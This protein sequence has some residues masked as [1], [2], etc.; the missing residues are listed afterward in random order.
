MLLSY[1]QHATLLLSHVKKDKIWTND[2]KARLFS[3]IQCSPWHKMMACRHC[4]PTLQTLYGSA[5]HCKRH[6]LS[7]HFRWTPTAQLCPREAFSFPVELLLIH[8]H[9]QM[10]LV[11]N[12]RQGPLCHQCKNM[13]K[14]IS[15]AA[16]KLH[17]RFPVKQLQMPSQSKTDIGGVSSVL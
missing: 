1:Y 11:Y 4:R 2:A 12:T 10:L 16:L 15:N 13:P 14:H 9:C 3:L 5:V 7:S 8:L 17:D 6:S